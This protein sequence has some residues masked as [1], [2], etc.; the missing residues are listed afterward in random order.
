MPQETIP[1]PDPYSVSP[2]FRLTLE[3]SPEFILRV[4]APTKGYRIGEIASLTGLTPDALRFYERRG[5]LEAPARSQGR[6][7]I[8]AATAVDRIH[9]IK[10]AQALGFSLNEIHEL[11]R[12]NGKGGLRRCCRV[13]ELLRDR[14]GEL[15]TKLAELAALQET[16][17]ATLKQCE[18]A[19]STKNESAC[20]VIEF[21]TEKDGVT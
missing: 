15:E 18:R 21:A 11:V 3:C 14:L 12:F 1:R 6:F 7:R 13:R 8:Y 20:P 10:R 5:L 16:L 19:I 9:F 4:M 2:D 17:K